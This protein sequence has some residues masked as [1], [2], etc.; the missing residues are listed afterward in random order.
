MLNNN[1]GQIGCEKLIIR[2][3]KLY[4]DEDPKFIGQLGIGVYNSIDGNE[5]DQY[6]FSQ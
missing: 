5:I 6:V 2:M 3:I 1:G 4:D